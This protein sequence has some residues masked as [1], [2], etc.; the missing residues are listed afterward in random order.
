[1]LTAEGLIAFCS[2]SWWDGLTLNRVFV[3]RSQC[4]TISLI[5]VGALIIRPNLI[6]DKYE[7]IHANVICMHIIL[8]TTSNWHDDIQKRCHIYILY[9]HLALLHIMKIPAAKNHFMRKYFNASYFEWVC[10]RFFWV[11]NAILPSFDSVPPNKTTQIG[12]ILSFTRHTITFHKLNR[13][14]QEF[15]NSDAQLGD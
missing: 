1:M 9:R 14:F 15:Q 3:V 10:L 13:R 2:L 5:H 8:Q 4:K 12:Y 7:S 6:L 11:F